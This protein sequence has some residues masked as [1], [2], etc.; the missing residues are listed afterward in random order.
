MNP[1]VK[2]ERFDNGI[3][4]PFVAGDFVCIVGGH[5]KRGGSQK[6]DTAKHTSKL[7]AGV[8]RSTVLDVEI[9][10][11]QLGLLMDIMR[12][13]AR[14]MCAKAKADRIGETTVA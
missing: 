11:L 5:W 12:A 6:S 1:F 4:Q 3:D 10:T 2:G 9:S 8:S 13:D 7:E 14:Q